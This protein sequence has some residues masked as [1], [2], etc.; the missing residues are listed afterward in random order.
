MYTYITQHVHNLYIW[1][2]IYTIHQLCNIDVDVY[3][4]Y[5]HLI[6]IRIYNMQ[7]KM[8]SSFKEAS[9]NVCDAIAAVARRLCTSEAPTIGLDAF[10]ACRL[11]PL[12]KNPGV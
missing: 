1:I 8:C 9:A 11:V 10:L 2:C 6:Y 5:I 12:N 7:C 4:Y 3:I